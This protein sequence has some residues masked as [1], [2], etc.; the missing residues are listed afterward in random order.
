[1][2]LGEDI[3]SLIDKP[4]TF[5][6][7]EDAWSLQLC[8]EPLSAYVLLWNSVQT[9]YAPG[10]RRIQE[11]AMRVVTEI[12]W[13]LFYAVS[14]MPRGSPFCIKWIAETANMNPN[15]IVRMLG[16]LRAARL[17]PTGGRGGGKSA[18][19]F[20]AHHKA[21]VLLALAAPTPS[22][23]AAACRALAALPGAPGLARRFIG[24]PPPQSACG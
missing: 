1:M 20:E 10:A 11:P 21:N 12:R 4:W 14:Q 5:R 17:V 15:T 6:D 24:A 18:A 19:Y 23:A 8:L 16:I 13:P 3:T 22:Q 7:E 2:T 9:F